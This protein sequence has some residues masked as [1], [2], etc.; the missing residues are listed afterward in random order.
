MRWVGNCLD[1]TVQVQMTTPEPLIAL[2]Q[3]YGG[4]LRCARR[5]DGHKPVWE[6]Y[7]RRKV[8]DEF[9][10]ELEPYLRIKR[11]KVEAILEA[12]RL[13]GGKKQDGMQRYGFGRPIPADELAQRRAAYRKYLEA[14]A[15]VS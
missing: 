15:N 14:S 5:K 7:G 6:W 13:I 2:H 4:T 11:N 10:R 1:T 8:I 3:L 9:L 12:R